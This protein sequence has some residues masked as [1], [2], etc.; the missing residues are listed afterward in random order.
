M[1]RIAL[2]HAVSLTLTLALVSPALAAQAK[3]KS[4]QPADPSTACEHAVMHDIG[5]HHPGTHKIQLTQT[6]TWQQSSDESG[7]GGT[8]TALA[9]NNTPRSFEWSCVY[10]TTKNKAIDVKLERETEGSQPKKK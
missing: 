2:R 5:V 1:T 9:Q 6:R 3:S 8:G 10:S 7:F 4:K